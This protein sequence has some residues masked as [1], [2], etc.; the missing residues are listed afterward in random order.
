MEPRSDAEDIFEEYIDLLDKEGHR[1]HKDIA[2]DIQDSYFR[3][4]NKM[5]YFVIDWEYMNQVA[6]TIPECKGKNHILAGLKEAEPAYL[7]ILAH[8]EQVVDLIPTRIDHAIDRYYDGAEQFLL[9]P[10][11]ITA[12]ENHLVAMMWDME[13]VFK[14]VEKAVGIVE[15]VEGVRIEKGFY[16]RTGWDYIL[17][18]RMDNIPLEDS[19][20]IMRGFGRDAD[21]VNDAI[22]K[23]AGDIDYLRPKGKRIMKKP[24]YSGS[25][26]REMGREE[27]K[28]FSQKK[29]SLRK[30]LDKMKVAEAN[31][32][33]G[34]KPRQKNKEV[35]R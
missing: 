16:K 10:L 15:W 25:L 33:Y 4:L 34:A 8:Y 6:G 13:K 27:G 12:V 22:L 31:A 5:K 26:L 18:N 24:W 35:Q 30:R 21:W 17:D 1:A 11:P 14:P 32:E 28:E 29:P 23:M 3:L 7:S 20:W 2:K 19:L 9:K